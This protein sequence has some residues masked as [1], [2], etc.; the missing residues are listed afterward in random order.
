MAPNIVAL[1][2]LSARMPKAC[3]QQEVA[4]GNWVRLDCHAYNASSR[5]ITHLSVRKASLVRSRKT[6]FKPFR[7]S[8][9]MTRSMSAGL[10]GKP[11]GERAGGENP[12]DVVKAM[13]AESYPGTVDHRQGLEGPVKSQ[14]AV[15]SCTA[16][17]L[18]TTLD[19]AAIRAGKLAAN[20]A[21]GATSPNHVW[22]NY[23]IPQMGTAAD[24]SVGKSLATSAIWP[25][26]NP[27]ACMLSS[28][29][30]E[31]CDQAY[32]GAKPGSWRTNPT[33][34]GKYNAAN[35]KPAYKINVFEKFAT[36]P[37]NIDELVQALATG[38][39]LWVAFKIDGS[40]WTNSKMTNAVIPDWTNWTGGH[41]VV[42]SGYRQTPSGRQYLIHNSWGTSWGER[43][44]AWVS[45]AMVQKYMHYAY[46]VKI[47]GGVKKEDMTDDDCA[48]DELLD[49][50]T[51]L[52][53]TICPGDKRPSNG[54]G[55]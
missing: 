41:A 42:M 20:D 37:P 22:S 49:A 39:S 15:G 54:C 13:T 47:D 50:A 31:D 19:N 44:Y 28:P 3:G 17:S 8:P 55:G 30:F 27:E 21:S 33:V 16:F 6:V 35:A 4:P 5:A 43:G 52:C 48:P 45:E 23:G 38:T 24:A 51:G 25:E 18:S 14:G 11:G 12:L 32:P 7:F 10:R 34:L 53:A 29:E 2:G 46:K 40:K 1:R 36:L 26:N 9:R